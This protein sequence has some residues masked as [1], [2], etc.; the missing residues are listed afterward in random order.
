M[1]TIAKA[2]GESG[3]TKRDRRTRYNYLK[4]LVCG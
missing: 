1:R 2:A 4:K 3:W